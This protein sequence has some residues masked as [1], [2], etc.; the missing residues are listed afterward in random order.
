MR[1]TLGLIGSLTT[2]GMLTAMNFDDETSY[3]APAHTDTPV[4][5][6]VA[7]PKGLYEEMKRTPEMQLAYA[8][9][10]LEALAGAVTRDSNKLDSRTPGTFKVRA[11]RDRNGD[12]IVTGYT[13]MGQGSPYVYADTIAWTSPAC[14]KEGRSHLTHQFH[15]VDRGNS[16]RQSVWT[17]GSS[18]DESV[19]EFAGQETLT[20]SGSEYEARL[21][22]Y[23]ERAKK[24]ACTIQATIHP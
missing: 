2:V 7:T 20:V 5:Y 16:V 14:G 10:V 17:G 3:G 13:K 22:Q 12:L 21:A 8:E 1:Q 18:E 4:L 9:Q 6:D 23:R 19:V 24:A 11:V 15:Q